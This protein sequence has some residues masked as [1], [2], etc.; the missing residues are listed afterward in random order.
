MKQCQVMVFRTRVGKEVWM[1]AIAKLRN[2]VVIFLFWICL[3][4]KG[5]K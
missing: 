4:I 3:V 2:M 5:K 1:Q